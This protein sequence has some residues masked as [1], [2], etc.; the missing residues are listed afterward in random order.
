[1]KSVSIAILA[2]ISTADAVRVNTPDGFP[3]YT[4]DYHFNEDPHSVPNPLGGKPYLTSTQAKLFKN[5]Q[6]QLAREPDHPYPQH[7]VFAPEP[8][9]AFNYINKDPRYKMFPANSVL[10]QSN[11]DLKWEVTA[12]LGELDDHATLLREQDNDYSIGK[13]KFHGWTNPLGWRDDGEDDD[14]VLFQLKQK[15]RFDES[16]YDTPAD[17]GLDDETVINFVQI[18]VHDDEDADDIN[19]VL[20][21]SKEDLNRTPETISIEHNVVADNGR[22]DDMVL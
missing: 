10:M 7:N 18:A 13:A 19:T 1:M 21:I 3:V 5:E 16:G 6:S 14:V 11:S 22:D 8:V 9:Y 17:K 2:L 4:Q 12:D 20:Q 15:V